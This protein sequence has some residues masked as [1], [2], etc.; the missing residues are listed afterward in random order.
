MRNLRMAR[1]RE[2]FDRFMRDRRDGRHGADEA[3]A[4]TA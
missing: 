4:G 3:P 2:E 1:D